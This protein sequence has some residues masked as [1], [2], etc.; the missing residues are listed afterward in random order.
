[1]S[2]SNGFSTVWLEAGTTAWP[3]AFEVELLAGA[4]TAPKV[5][6]VSGSPLF[7]SSRMLAA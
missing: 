3:A 7:A 1:V 2:G 4:G 6:T 5:A